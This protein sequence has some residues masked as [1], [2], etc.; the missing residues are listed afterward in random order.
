VA[1]VPHGR[2]AARSALSGSS[3]AAARRRPSASRRRSSVQPTP[4][5]TRATRNPGG[6]LGRR[7]T[8]ASDQ[9]AELLEKAGAIGPQLLGDKLA[10]RLSFRR[11]RARLLARS[12]THSPP[13]L[14]KLWKTRLQNRRR[15]ALR[16]SSSERARTLS[17]SSPC[18]I[19][20]T[21]DGSKKR[22]ERARTSAGRSI[23][24][25]YPTFVRGRRAGDA[26]SSVR[27]SVLRRR[28]P[29]SESGP[30]RLAPR[31]AEPDGGPGRGAAAPAHSVRTSGVR[32]VPGQR[33][34][35][36]LT[37]PI[38]FVVNSATSRLPLSSAEDGARVALR[39]Q[40]IYS[41]ESRWLSPSRRESRS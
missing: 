39:S 5:I 8:A 25:S 2:R 4:S 10:P 34:L 18:G 16:R 23:V 33:R 32:R 36:R 11:R 3:A 15:S 41:P 35:E 9:R 17:R 12:R 24:R 22:S 20:R 30:G 40:P 26:L 6:I 38:S 29:A 37:R 14:W 7:R 13:R 1:R 28:P 27:R 31:R 21:R 19:T